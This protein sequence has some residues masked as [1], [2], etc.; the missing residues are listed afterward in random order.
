[1]EM[2]VAGEIADDFSV[3]GERVAPGI[4]LTGLAHRP[5]ENVATVNE[6]IVGTRAL[7]IDCLSVG[8]GA[9]S[10][11]GTQ[12]RVND[13]STEEIL[14]KIGVTRGIDRIEAN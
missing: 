10:P 2:E 13:G 12:L 1:M 7:S 4:I 9:E 5:R 14:A 11:R 8:R 6:G 3:V